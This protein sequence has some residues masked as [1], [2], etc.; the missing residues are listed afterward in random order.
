MDPMGGGVS[1]ASY[2][3]GS[4]LHHWGDSSTHWCCQGTGIEAFAR[5]ADSIYWEPNPEFVGQAVPEHAAP[6]AH[7]FVLQAISSALRWTERG[8]DVVLDAEAPGSRSATEPLRTSLRLLR[9]STSGKA[10]WDGEVLLWLRVPAWA[11]G[12]RASAHGALSLPRPAVAGEGTERLLPVL[13]TLSTEPQSSGSDGD[14]L[15][16]VHLQWS[17]GLR[18]ERIQ[19]SRARFQVLHAV[20]A[21]GFERDL[22]HACLCV[23]YDLPL[24]SRDCQAFWGPLVLAGDCSGIRTR[25]PACMPMCYL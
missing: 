7:L 2:P 9:P 10:T 15:G 5:L 24:E 25:S 3:S 18:W 22:P 8:C 21:V 20:T 11:K 16:R 19:D 12:V 17:M 14:V 1:K 13:G 23:T 6:R 4:E